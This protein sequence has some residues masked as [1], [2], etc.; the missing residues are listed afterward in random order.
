MVFIV[1][2]P[3]RSRG[4]TPD[5]SAP[6][7]PSTEEGPAQ[8]QSQSNAEP[9][10]AAAVDVLLAPSV[11]KHRYLRGV[12]KSLIVERPERVRAVLLGVAGAIGQLAER[13]PP[14]PLPSSDDPDDLVARLGSLSVN[15]A[16]SDTAMRIPSPVPVRVLH[17]TRSLALDP[18]HPAVAYVH[19]HSD[20]TVQMLDPL[21]ANKR[22]ETIVKR[23]MDHDPTITSTPLAPSPS[24]QDKA[25]SS[26]ATAETSHAAYLAYLCSLAPNQPPV[27]QLQAHANHASSSSAAST[28]T[29]DS[30]AYT[31][32]DGEGDEALHPS[33]I[34]EHLP[35]GDLYLAGPEDG[36]SSEAIRHAI[37]AC[38][39]AVDRVVAASRGTPLATSLPEVQY[40]A[41]LFSHPPPTL[42]AR[43]AFV[44]S[45]P[46]GHHCAGSSPSGF[47]WVNN[48]VVAASHAYLEHGID[49]VVIFDID[50][51]H[52]NGTQSLAWRI[53]ADAQRHDLEREARMPPRRGTGRKSLEAAA[54]AA[55]AAAADVGPRA[56]RLFYSSIHDIESFPCEDGDPTLIKDA[57]VCVEGAHG[58]WIWNGE[59]CAS[60]QRPSTVSHDY[61]CTDKNGKRSE[62][63]G[64]PPLRRRS[65]FACFNGNGAF[66]SGFVPILYAMRT[67]AAARWIAFTFLFRNEKGI[68]MS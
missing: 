9:Q 8:S 38:A 31:S 32:S 56:L 16:P 6:A 43:R 46:P 30:E 3:N 50:L 4:G 68:L 47:C 66:R 63:A 13:P 11:L 59:Y 12:D 33:E 21:Y 23:E 54:A 55:A 36:G 62:E 34:P 61:T 15:N 51:H 35:Q 18:P 22:G 48:A 26:S 19:A 44:I 45:R 2:I 10:A 14:T 57:S 24:T 27:S 52:G 37:G 25:I 5:P 40:H 58:Q 64:L 49:R 28:G 67:N 20:E 65:C 42:P 60:E 1:K 39:E 29:I 53:N 7:P 41:E 17:S